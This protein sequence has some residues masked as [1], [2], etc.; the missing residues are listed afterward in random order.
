MESPIIQPNL[1]DNLPHDEGFGSTSGSNAPV[2]AAVPSAANA[3]PESTY[4]QPGTVLVI[5]RTLFNYVIIGIVFF[6]LGAVIGGAGVGALF[7]AN[8]TEN[9]ALITSAVSQAVAD[10][11]GSAAAKT[12]LQPGQKYDI[13]VNDTDPIYGDPNSP[14]TIVEFSDFHC[15][16]CGR[17]VKETLK[18]LM[19]AYEGKAKLI[20]RN[21]PILGQGSVLAA[22]AGGCA[23]D[24]GKF[25]E[26][27]D[28]V[29]AD[30]Q[31][32]TRDAF[33]K[34]AGE[35]NLDVDTFTKCFDQQDHMSEIQ[36]DYTYAQNLGATGTPTFFINGHYVS[37]AQPY[38]VFAEAIDKE[39]GAVE[40][41]KPAGTTATS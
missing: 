35:M 3:Q 15:P 28:L 2:T 16:Y 21:Y 37:G 26:F 27:H 18:P 1:T 4:A 19:D 25:W 30:Q 7:N 24:Q 9:Q 31:D 40:E 13:T 5:P 33:V 10:A 39:L 8:S 22:L 17:F 32:L 29:F 23:R 11:G 20:F 36:A 41:S 38:A 6:V 12:G 34:Y 14:V